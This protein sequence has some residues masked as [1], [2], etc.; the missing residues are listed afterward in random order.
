MQVFMFCFSY[1][2]NF[3]YKIQAYKIIGKKELND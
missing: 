2:M 3:V 1:K